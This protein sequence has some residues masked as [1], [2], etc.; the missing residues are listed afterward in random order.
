MLP[1]E[2]K[3]KGG[4]GGGKG[5][6]SRRY[7][8]GVCLEESGRSHGRLRDAVHGGGQQRA[9]LGVIQLKGLGL[10]V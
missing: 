6:D 10:G 8:E 5:L 3:K 4:R 2:E 1:W 7:C 9:W